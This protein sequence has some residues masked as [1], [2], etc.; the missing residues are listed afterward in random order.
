[1][2]MRTGP[3]KSQLSFLLNQVTGGLP[4]SHSLRFTASKGSTEP[5]GNATGNCGH[6]PNL[7]RSLAVEKLQ[8]LI[9]VAGDRMD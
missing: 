8:R 9:E 7:R 1:M 3:N 6:K 5:P 2:A 4:I